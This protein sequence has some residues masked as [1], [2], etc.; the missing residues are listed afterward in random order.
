MEG[1]EPIAA[2]NVGK[3]DRG[4]QEVTADPS[5]DSLAATIA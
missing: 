3:T 2:P 1:T 5:G 4:A